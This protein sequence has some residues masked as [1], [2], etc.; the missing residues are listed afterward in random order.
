METVKKFSQQKNVRTRL[1]LI[2][3]PRMVTCDISKECEIAVST[4]QNTHYP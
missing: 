3:I 2:M 1:I 4:S